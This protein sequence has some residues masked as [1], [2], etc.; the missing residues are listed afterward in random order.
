MTPFRWTHEHVAAIAGAAPPPAPIIARTDVPHILSGLDLWDHWP[1][2]EE[3]GRVAAIAGGALVMALTAPML[4]NPEDRHAIARLRLLHRVAGRWRD[5]GP[6]LPDGFSPGSREWAGSAT[7]DP[8]HERVTAYF[9][10]AG[11]RGET[12]TT[13]NQRMFE[14]S[15]ALAIVG[16]VPRLAGWTAPVEIAQP[17]GTR[18]ETEMA[19]GGAVGSIKAFRDPFH[20]RRD[21]ADYILFAGSRSGATSKWN[22]LVGAARRDVHGGWTLLDPLVDADGVNNE[23]ERPHVVMHNGRVYVFWSTQAKVFAP[24]L[25]GPTGLYG[26]VADDLDRLW[27]PLNGHGLVF[28]NPPQAP[29]QAFSWQVLADLTIWGFADL[30]GLARVPRDAAEARRHFGGVPAPVLQLVLRDD[31]AWLS[32]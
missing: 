18:Y 20:F 9:T 11:R 4:S 7:I 12:V 27:R 24:G 15:A 13:F 23:L 1:V 22:G 16:G 31:R 3:D 25:G 8:V 32:S 26:V 29:A 10:A 30:V 2:L 21:Q 17:D 5:L 28:A 6:L 14:T 19:G